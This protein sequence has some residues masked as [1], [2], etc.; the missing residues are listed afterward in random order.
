MTDHPVLVFF[1]SDEDSISS[2]NMVFPPALYL[3]YD[4]QFAVDYSGS[5]ERNL[6]ERE[7]PDGHRY[8]PEIIGAKRLPARKLI[9]KCLRR[10][11]IR[12]GPQVISVG[13]QHW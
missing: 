11:R 4:D 6:R 2:L 13:Y 3:L 8:L 5:C 10:R 1:F 7:I 9:A 12:R